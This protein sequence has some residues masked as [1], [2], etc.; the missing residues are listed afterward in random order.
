MFVLSKGKSGKHHFTLLAK[1]QRVI[2]TS[3]AYN[4]R[5]AA[6]DGI[7]SVKKNATQRKHFETRTARNGKRYFALL[8]HN[9]EII[10]QSQMYAGL[11]SVYAGIRSVMA[12]APRAKLLDTE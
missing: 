9:G 6:F 5:Q 8:A 10:G 11:S 7:K 4:S 12:N 2:L 1:N 3:E